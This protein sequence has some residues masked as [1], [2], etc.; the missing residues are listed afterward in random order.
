[1]RTRS[2]LKLLHRCRDCSAPIAWATFVSGKRAPFDLHPVDEAELSPLIPLYRFRY[3]VAYLT[4]P[5][6][7]DGLDV[8]TCHLDTCT[9]ESGAA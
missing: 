2:G 3:G 5:I 7:S 4:T 6:A 9:A 8:Y 1:M